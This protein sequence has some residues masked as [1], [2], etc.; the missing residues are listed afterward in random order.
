MGALSPQW[1]PTP[2]TVGVCGLGWKNTGSPHRAVDSRGTLTAKS[3]FTLDLKHSRELPRTELASPS[4]QE[5]RL[6]RWLLIMLAVGAAGT[7]GYLGTVAKNSFS[8]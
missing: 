1:N 6:M 3:A 2:E 5:A 7:A 8:D 4:R